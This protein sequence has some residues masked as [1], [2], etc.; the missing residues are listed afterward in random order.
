[1]P[2]RPRGELAGGLLVGQSFEVSVSEELPGAFVVRPGCPYVGSERRK[3]LVDPSG[4][5]VSFV[6]STRTA[7]FKRFASSADMR[8]R[9]TRRF[10]NS[11]VYCQ[12]QYSAPSTPRQLT[13]G[14]FHNSVHRWGKL[15]A[16]VGRIVEALRARALI[17][18]GKVLFLAIISR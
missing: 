6:P 11:S 12:S 17:G 2:A 16:G 10:P 8:Q 9:V 4:L 15:G 14:P 13:P 7:S 3:S 5:R 18:N 1:M